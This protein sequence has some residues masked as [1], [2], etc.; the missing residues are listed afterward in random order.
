MSKRKY[1]PE[2]VKALRIRYKNGESVKDLA[3]EYG[4]SIN[5]MHSLWCA[6]GLTT[7]YPLK[8]RYSIPLKTLKEIH[9]RWCDG[10]AL[11]KLAAEMGIPLGSLRYLLKSANLKLVRTY[12]SPSSPNSEA[13]EPMVK[14]REWYR[15]AYSMRLN[16]H[17]W[18][19]IYFLVA[20]D[21][22]AGKRASFIKSFSR[23]LRRNNIKAYPA[24]N[25]K[26]YIKPKI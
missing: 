13:F 15:I 24:K 8:N 12:S 9:Q 10:T 22:Y 25:L 6:H 4:V 7:T 26:R 19:D 18:D 16:G 23:W 14:R 21:G 20:Q 2:D 17:T 11:S 3:E 5:R 1:M